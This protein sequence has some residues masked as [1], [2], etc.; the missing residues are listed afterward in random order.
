[1]KNTEVSIINIGHR[2]LKICPQETQVCQI[3]MFIS[4]GYVG[5][6]ITL[7]GETPFAHRS[8]DLRAR[9][10]HIPVPAAERLGT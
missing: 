8:H 6:K 5:R 2:V 1:M 9:D 4:D 3:A 10:V 7:L